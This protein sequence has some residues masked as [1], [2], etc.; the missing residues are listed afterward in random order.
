M[1]RSL[2]VFII[3]TGL[4]GFKPVSEWYQYQSKEGSYKISMPAEPKEQTQK[5]PTAVGELTMFI[6]ML[7]SEESDANLLYMS[8]YSEYPSEKISSTMGNESTD[9]FFKGAAEGAA[10]NM[11]GTVRS[12]KEAN[13]KGFPGKMIYCDISLA[14]Q[15]FVAQQ[16]LILVK[17]KFYM[18]QTFTRVGQEDNENS[19]KFFESF[20][21]PDIT[22][23]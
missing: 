23:N 8:A 13:Y 9:R 6:A 7:E 3:V 16:K 1:T 10:K 14:G 15:D 18:L 12:M 19:K 17:N 21:L 2:L 5:I 20:E 4:F 22:V 11:N